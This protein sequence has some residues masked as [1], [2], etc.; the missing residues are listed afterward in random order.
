LIKYYYAFLRPA[1]AAALTVD[2][3]ELPTKGWGSLTLTDSV[4]RVGACTASELAAGAV[5]C[6]LAG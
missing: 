3:C 1:E 4:K 2:N 5:T 6:G